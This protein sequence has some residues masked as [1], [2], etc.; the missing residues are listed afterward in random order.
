MHYLA[1]LL[2]IKPTSSAL[3][4]YHCD[5]IGFIYRLGTTLRRI[6]RKV[7][8]GSLEHSWLLQQ[9]TSGTHTQDRAALLLI[10]RNQVVVLQGRLNT[11]VPAPVEARRV[12][13]IPRF[14]NPSPANIAPSPPLQPTS[15]P[16]RPSTK[17]APQLLPERATT[18]PVT[19][20]IPTVLRMGLR[21]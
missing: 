20:I 21:A 1:L 19:P 3:F 6:G 12:L 16:D 10:N 11:R 5:K 7:N 9:L 18:V 8:R 2:V 4:P 17:A 15:N 14:S 13:I